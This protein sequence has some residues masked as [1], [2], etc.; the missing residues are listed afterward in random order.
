MNRSDARAT[1]SSDVWIGEYRLMHST[2]WK[3]VV[4]IDGGVATFKTSASAECAAWRT[5][6]E[7]QE[8]SVVGEAID[9]VA[10]VAYRTR[11]ARQRAE[12]M[13]RR[14]T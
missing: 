6:H 11:S 10:A 8:G 9:P 5:L 2:R 13:F 14:R 12:S 4:G 1:K 3:P 7:I